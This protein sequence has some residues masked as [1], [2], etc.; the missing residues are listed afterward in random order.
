MNDSYR[1]EL[2]SAY[3]DNEVTDAERA[4]V[5]QWLAESVEFRQLHEE[6][7]AM[8]QELR[9]L[10][11][12]KLDRDLSADVLRRAEREVLSGHSTGNGQVTP[13]STVAEWWSRPKSRR[14]WFWPALAAAAALLIALVDLR[15]DAPERQVAREDKLVSAAG[16]KSGSELYGQKD[17]ADRVSG[18]VMARSAK[19]AD[20]D[21]ADVAPRGAM[22][23]LDTAIKQV[24]EPAA[25][26]SPESD[27]SVS[28]GAPSPG[29]GYAS[30]ANKS[31]AA[32]VG[33]MN[34]AGA[35]KLESNVQSAL[36]NRSQL[37]L[38]QCEVSPDYLRDKRLDKFLVTNSITYKKL[39]EAQTTNY[40][41]Y[42][43]AQ[44]LEQAKKIP[45]APQPEALY[46]VEATPEQ[47]ELIV[48]EL[49]RDR[50]RVSNLSLGLQ[51]LPAEQ[52][53]G[54]PQA[55]AS[56]AKAPA[57]PTMRK[58]A[59]AESRR[60]KLQSQQPVQI[61]LRQTLPGGAAAKP[62]AA[63]APEAEPVPPP[64]P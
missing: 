26:A 19:P 49:D 30:P 53:E 16:E 29:Q 42:F 56:A 11:T 32:G 17:G 38:I 7:R 46:A 34:Q 62:A 20:A 57:A 1:E 8:R 50:A 25:G 3:L 13:R 5:E 9:S 41:L 35:V 60:A 55:E 24:A 47:V 37:N 28:K 39:D 15:Q 48:H 18:R 40:H 64:Q 23:S 43:Q 14:M 4:Q 44:Q 31:T 12:H 45:Q 61:W 33:V 59:A 2:L 58:E 36:A 54:A 10:P 21:I 6:L 27:T 51:L 52:Q 22:P 63:P